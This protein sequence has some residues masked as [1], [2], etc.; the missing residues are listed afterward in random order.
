MGNLKAV[1]R[2]GAVLVMCAAV[3][4]AQTT[5]GLIAGRLVNSQTG[6]PVS[7]AQVSYSNAATGSSGV[8]TS[9]ARGNFFLPMLSPGQYRIRATAAGFQSREVQEL[10]LPVA[11]RLE[12]NF[13][14][15]P[16]NDVW[17]AGQYRSV[18][19][20]GSKTIVTFYGP[21][22]DSSRSG[23]FE[24]TQGRRG[25][26]ESTVSQVIDPAQVR[27]LPLAG[28]DV[29]TML[30]TQPGVTAD[31]AT[32]RG[33]GLS[34]NGQRPSSSN[35]LL[36]GL[37]NN[38]YLVTGPLTPIAPE[39]I[40]EYRVST[41]NFSAE[42]GRT[43]GF[44]ANAVTRSGGNQFHGIGYF[45]LKNDALNANGFQ[46]NLAGLPRAPVKENQI[47][48]QAGGPIRKQTLFFSTAYEHQRSR[49]RQDATDFR[50]PTTAFRQFLLSGPANRIS[51]KLFD[52]FPGPT[53]TA[54]TALT[55]TV[56]IAPPVSVDR[57]LAIER[58]DY[59]SRNGLNRVMGRVAIAR[60]SRPD[61]IWSPYKDFISGLDQD[62]LSVAVSYIRALR[63][64]LMNEA[65][66]GRNSDDLGWDRPHPEI[67]TLSTSEVVRLPNGF[68]V[69]VPVYLPGSPAFYAYRNRNKTW[70]LL[71]SLVW[72]HGRHVF[73]AGG[74]A[75]LR[76]SDG[77]LTAG[78][79]GEYR[80]GTVFDF[81]LDQPGVF[82]TSVL[83]Q[84]LPNLQQPDFNR[85]YRYNQ[86]FLFA[87]DTFKATSRLALNY[88]V[89]YEQYG[90]PRNTGAV[91]DATVNL[92]TGSNFGQRL[93][94][95]QLAYP[96][97]G[98]QQLYKPD[99]NDWAGR[100]GFSYDLLGNARTLLRGAYG[101][102]YDRP[103]DN[104]W[105]NLRTNN[106]V[107]PTFAVTPRTANY[108]TP[109]PEQLKN[110]D[111]RFIDTSFPNL[112]LYD[113]SSRTAYVQSY[114]FGVQQQV[115]DNW[116]I[117]INGLGSLGRKLIVSDIV[118]RSY[119]NGFSRY[120]DN[121]DNITYRSSQGLSNYNALTALA[122]YRAGRK[123]F[124]LAYTWSH[125]I[126][127]QSEPLARDFFDL[128]FTRIG[129]DSSRSEYSAFSYQFDT[130]ID[131]GNSDFDQRHNVVFFSIWD[132]PTA[133]SGTKAGAV[134]RDW[135][136]SQLAAFR[137]GFPYSVREPIGF[138]P[139]NPISL[140]NGRA[141]VLD[142]NRAV[143]DT[144]VSVSGGKL[145]LNPGAFAQAP[146]SR[147][148]NTG[149][150]AFRGPG[151]YNVDISL[152]RSFPLRW[153]G[154][155]GRLTFR[156]DVFNFLNHANL[157]NPQPFINQPDFGVA[158]YGRQGKQSGFPA[159]SPFNET[160]RQ[161][162]LILRLEF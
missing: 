99:K 114:F 102:F 4:G 9:D 32:A 57:T 123:Q 11:A 63:P 96:G 73:T 128:L 122:R 3:A 106:F 101:I 52:Q 133:F 150:N 117:E 60:L 58:L 61:F 136:F 162:Q 115:T 143:L 51:R 69:N 112:T 7:G 62:T 79:D 19:L 148:G 92:G 78:R 70:E 50:L 47:G 81:I 5:Q 119:S 142:P 65:K 36:D 100:F 93:A 26:L 76:S 91:K 129:P 2:L 138:D 49:S 46:E 158:L 27:D 54:T 20:P 111:G 41:N 28:R 87:Q 130:R 110:L 84:P 131:R 141:D 59:N 42:Y 149:R 64:G 71:D 95:A 159:V 8:A 45:Y 34:I 35:F 15:R 48:F 88:G 121:L 157:N 89:R 113:Q 22:V 135:R 151:L 134:F 125:T 97:P 29:Y 17:E 37:E 53:I 144:P 161:V 160:A 105:Q 145:L 39:A 80:F 86:Y 132:L 139:N 108:L 103:Y 43:A 75:L 55:A 33:L 38:N 1:T 74:G 146:A 107:L 44:L 72:T 156:S 23:S 10:E 109:I 98:D 30:V 67:P 12:L 77:F 94:T 152:S 83:R 68:G 31:T 18:F 90:A 82:R 116:A 127:H 154:E 120:N 104:L 13:Q 153:L 137:S 16:L 147:Q 66:L 14:L 21:D 118:N 126:D 24:A 25:A 6:A 155:A 140:Y 40:Q 56:S 85:E 124:Q